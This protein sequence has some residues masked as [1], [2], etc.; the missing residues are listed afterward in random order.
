[1]EDFLTV[2]QGNKNSFWYF[3][4][5]STFTFCFKQSVS[6]LVRSNQLEITTFFSKMPPKR[7]HSAALE[8]EQTNSN[9]KDQNNNTIESSTTTTTNEPSRKKQKKETSTPTNPPLNS[10]SSKKIN[11]GLLQ[12]KKKKIR[13]IVTSFSW[14][15]LK[16]IYIS[17]KDLLRPPKDY[18][19]KFKK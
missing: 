11:L 15:I 16:M 4:N 12:N 9:A 19:R 8:S 18:W 2:W 6:L 7:L 10:N 14:S 17:G 13:G 1:M 3:L 5:K